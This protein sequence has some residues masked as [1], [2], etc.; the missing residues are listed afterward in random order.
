[1][2]GHGAAV[3]EQAAVRRCVQAS[4]QNVD[5]EGFVDYIHSTQQQILSSAEALEGN[6]RTFVRDKWD[7]GGPAEPN[8]GYG[9]TCVLEDGEVLEK[10]AASITVVRGSLTAARAAAMSSRG[11][12]CIDPAGGQAYAAAALSLV[13]HSAHPMIP[14]LRADVRLFQVGEQSWFGGGCDLTPFYVDSQDFGSFHSF[15][16]AQCD[17]HSPEA[18][19][20]Y[21]AV[22]DSY[23]YIPARKEHRGVG[24]IFFDDLSSEE[25]GFDVPAF[26]KDVGTGILPSWLPIVER[27]R[28]KPISPE[29]R[30][31][32]GLDGGRMEAIMVSAPPLIRWRY[33]IVPEIGSPESDLVEL[34][35]KPQQWA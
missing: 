1:M 15:W 18:Y 14:T 33:N 24:G 22:C 19:S 7:R 12:G 17:T 28:Q 2:C 35:R 13:F 16:K 23:F 4:A 8:A 9:L 3:R 25:A 26:V 31:K 6:R 32:F 34:L 5:F 21:K 10:A 11:R 20:E 29:Q 30:V 27:H